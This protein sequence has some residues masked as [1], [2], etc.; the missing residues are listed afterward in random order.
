MDESEKEK[1]CCAVAEHPHNIEWS[2]TI[3]TSPHLTEREE[4]TI[5]SYSA[6]RLC[7]FGRVSSG[8]V[9]NRPT[10]CKR[11]LRG[12]FPLAYKLGNPHI[13]KRLCVTSNH[14]GRSRVNSEESTINSNSACQ[15]SAF[16]WRGIQMRRCLCGEPRLDR[17]KTTYR[18]RLCWFYGEFLPE[19]TSSGSPML[20]LALCHIA[21][22]GEVSDK[23]GCVND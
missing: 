12:I 17:K 20:K 14:V 6:C 23:Y 13:K 18:P 4:S 2:K 16:G 15:L 8:E 22:C 21:P 19:R 5:S 9:D 10:P 1:Y 7:A 11:G 3:E